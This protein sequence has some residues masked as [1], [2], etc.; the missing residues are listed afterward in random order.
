MS[1]SRLVLGL[2]A[3]LA[4]LTFITLKTSAQ[5]RQQ[6]QSPDQ[7]P[8]RVKAEPNKV[9]REWPK[10]VEPI[11]T[12]AER[13][14]YPKLQTDEER[15]QFIDN[16][17]RTR[18]PDPDTEENEY[19]DEYYERIQYA[20][21]H[22]SS[23]KPGWLTD[24]GRIYV[25]FGKPDDVESHPAGGQYERAYYEGTGS[26]AVYPFE[27]WFYRNLPGVRSGVE[28]EFVDPSG[29]GEY[30]IARNPFEKEVIGLNNGRSP[31]EVSMIG[32]RDYKRDQDSPFEWLKLLRDLDAPPTFIKQDSG[33]TKNH[34]PVTDDS[35][36]NL[37]IVDHYFF[38]TDGRVIT[39]FTIQ[40]DNRELV[41]QDS[42]G[43]QT[44][45]L[46]I[47]GRITSVAERRIGAFEDSVTTT[48]TVEELAEAKER[49][50]AYGKALIL[51]PGRYRLD[52]YVRDIGSGALGVAHHSFIVP[53]LDPA[54]LTNS[55]LVLCAKLESLNDRPG[56]GQFT[57]GL[58]KVVP[59][60]SGVY[61]HG[62]PVGIYMQVYNVGVD[63]TTL[64]P[65]VDVEYVLLKDGRE[66]SKQAEDWRGMSDAGLRLTLA[67]L[68]DTSGLAPG[69]YEIQI[70]IRDHVSGQELAPATVF[71]LVP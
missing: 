12:D 37:E 26:A 66:L 15:A 64:R 62:Q 24:R 5:P 17:W 65:A 1:R 8:R 41:F 68:I 54:K 63:Q 36:L 59:N 29:T 61:H 60:I 19:K 71:K 55:S 47:F 6:A 33:M 13:K 27:R 46:N 3:L 14:A 9:F 2:A 23:G 30:R 39:A 20:N 49:K 69:T 4:S 7:Q 32:V 31:D 38:Q 35:T 42:G 40:A 16:F 43:L 56:G 28:I 10:E 44:A 67:R 21:E 70:R 48:A 34:G 25:K 57:I 52:V 22:F 11:M 50:S 58:T 18:D 45:R 53:T 51:A